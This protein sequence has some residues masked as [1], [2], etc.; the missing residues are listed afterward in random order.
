[1]I[2]ELPLCCSNVSH[3]IIQ[4]FEG[5]QNPEIAVLG[6]LPVPTVARFIRINPQ[7]WYPNGTICLRA[8]IL[9][10]RVD[11]NLM[12]HIEASTLE[13]TGQQTQIYAGVCLQIQPTA[14]TQRKTGFPKTPWTSGT[15]TTTR[16]GR[17]VWGLPE[18]DDWR[19]FT[20]KLNS[21]DIFL[22]NPRI[23]PL[24]SEL[25]LFLGP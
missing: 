1:M 2:V 15:I 21:L 22:T 20:Q 25:T 7:T 23:N 8:E 4:I 3:W 5:S 6:L 9:G 13:L 24:K 11:G 17:W 16:W 18:H 10:C 19:V 12:V 14:W